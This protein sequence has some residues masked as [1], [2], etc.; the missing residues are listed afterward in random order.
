MTFNPRVRLRYW[1]AFPA[2]VV[3][4]LATTAV[5]AGDLTG[6]GLPTDA[7]RTAEKPCTRGLARL[8]AWQH[9]MLPACAC[10][11]EASVG[12][13]THTAP[14]YAND[15]RLG[16]SRCDKRSTL[17][18]G[19]R[20]RVLPDT[21]EWEEPDDE[22]D[23]DWDA[24]LGMHLRYTACTHLGRVECFGD[25]VAANLD[26]PSSLSISSVRLRC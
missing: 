11:Q 10:A 15:Y 24:P 25:S 26:S 2:F 23:D 13:A 21:I 8:L 19:K 17:K 6:S 20:S 4:T 7:T 14:G 18:S 1:L 5:S 9:L 22:V 3:S 12:Q 16:S